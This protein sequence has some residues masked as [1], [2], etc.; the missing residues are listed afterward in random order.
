MNS[1]IHPHYNVFIPTPTQSS[2][3]SNPPGMALPAGSWKIE[4]VDHPTITASKNGGADS[5]G[6]PPKAIFVKLSEEL[7]QQLKAASSSGTAPISLPFHLELATSSAS[8]GSSSSS[9]IKGS[10]SS[11][12]SNHAS[13]SKAASSA[14]QAKP[15]VSFVPRSN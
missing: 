11:S 14:Q 6:I 4:G 3:G 12:S 13:G 2:T 7:L 8:S 10:S 9:S 15:V 1:A 5:K